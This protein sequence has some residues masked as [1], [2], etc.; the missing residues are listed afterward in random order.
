MWQVAHSS[1]DNKKTPRILNPLQFFVV[2]K[3]ERGQGVECI[4][5]R[6]ESMPLY[7]CPDQR[8]PLIS[9]KLRERHLYGRIFSWSCYW[10]NRPYFLFMVMKQVWMRPLVRS[11]RQKLFNVTWFPSLSCCTMCMPTT[12]LPWLLLNIVRGYFCH[13]TYW[14]NLFFNG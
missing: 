3:R 13:L 12:L 2:W 7:A 14:I 1:T 11:W 9:M 4:V 6:R 10:R 8:K 5:R